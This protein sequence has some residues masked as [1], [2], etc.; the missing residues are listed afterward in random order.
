MDLTQQSFR[1]EVLS[2]GKDNQLFHLLISLAESAPSCWNLIYPELYVNPCLTWGELRAQFEGYYSGFRRRALGSSPVGA[3]TLHGDHQFVAFILRHLLP[4]VPDV[5]YFEWSGAP[6]LTQDA[7]LPIASTIALTLF[8]KQAAVYVGP[9]GMWQ[10]EGSPSS[11][12]YKSL[13]EVHLDDMELRGAFAQ[14]QQLHAISTALVVW[15]SV[16]K[17]H[18]S[19]PFHTERAF[20]ALLNALANAFTQGGLPHLQQLSLRPQEETQK[21]YVLDASSLRTQLAH[22]RGVDQVIEEWLNYCSASSVSLRQLC[23]TQLSV[24]GAYVSKNLPQHLRTEVRSQAGA[25]SFCTIL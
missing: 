21:P 18:W 2:L 4:Y 3:L 6:A 11:T 22:A 23:L 25:Q 20:R 17:I 8:P 14:P 24:R 9:V 5:R 7:A 15:R 19:S 1:L 13:L 10:W 12:A 16:T